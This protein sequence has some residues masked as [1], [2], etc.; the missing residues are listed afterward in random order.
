M[1]FTEYRAYLKN[2]NKIVNV[3]K[4]NFVEEYIEY[5]DEKGNTIIA[6]FE[7]IELS[8]FIGLY[9]KGNVPI[10]ENDIV[11]FFDKIYIVKYDKDCTSFIACNEDLKESL[12]FGNGNN[13]KM[14]VV[15]NGFIK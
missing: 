5:F 7:E 10:Y 13:K 1:P 6:I 3:T 11:E 8:Q 4:I 12:R 9:A 2:R 15:G 14:L